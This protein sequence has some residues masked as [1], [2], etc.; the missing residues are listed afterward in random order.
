MT[1]SS[2]ISCWQWHFRSAEGEMVSEL[3]KAIHDWA[4][5]LHD[6]KFCTSYQPKN[7]DL[8]W[9]RLDLRKPSENTIQGRYL[10]VMASTYYSPLWEAGNLDNFKQVFLDCVEC[11]WLF[12]SIAELG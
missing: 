9:T 6:V 10:H 12:L 11:T 4:D 3:R 7:L 8:P 5:H 1:L 2:R